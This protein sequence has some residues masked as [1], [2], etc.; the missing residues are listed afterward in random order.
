MRCTESA[1]V[2]QN[3]FKL[4]DLHELFQVPLTQVLL[5]GSIKYALHMCRSSLAY[6]AFPKSQLKGMLKVTKNT[7]C[8]AYLHLQS[9]GGRM[10]LGPIVALAVNKFGFKWSSVFGA[11]VC[12]FAMI[13]CL[14]VKKFLAFQLFYGILTGIGSSFLYVPANTCTGFFF[15]KRK[16]LAFGIASAGANIGLV[17]A[18]VY[19]A[20]NN[21]F[22]M[23]GI[24]V[25]YTCMRISL[26]PLFICFTLMNLKSRRGQYV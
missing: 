15:Q 24:F 23:K 9:A 25:F 16:S 14:L 21:S 22:Q 5:V 18:M 10:I 11:A 4:Q 7:D 8:G 2:V 17:L 26:I 13:G 6:D 3:H 19:G 12:S 1:K 20:I